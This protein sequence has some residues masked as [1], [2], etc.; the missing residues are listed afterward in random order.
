MI[1]ETFKEDFRSQMRPYE[2]KW[3]YQPRP[4]G[5]ADHYVLVSFWSLR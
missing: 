5:V 3:E 1:L 4:R 2:N